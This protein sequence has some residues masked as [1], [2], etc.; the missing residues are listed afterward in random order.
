M[1]EV[2]AGLQVTVALLVLDRMLLQLVGLD[3]IVTSITLAGLE[4]LLAEAILIYMAVVVRDTL[5][6]AAMVQWQWAD[7][8][9][10][11]AVQDF[12]EKQT[13]PKP[14]MERQVHV[15]RAQEQMMDHWVVLANPVP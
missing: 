4:V 7:K 14:V 15:A 13:M 12:S 5:I 8:V 2:L 11:A 3:L 6:W 1:L 9:T 10:L